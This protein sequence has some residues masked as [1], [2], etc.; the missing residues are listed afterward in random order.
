MGKSDADADA[1]AVAASATAGIEAGRGKYQG[2][3]PRNRSQQNALRTTTAPAFKESV[4]EMN[5][6]VLQC[7][8]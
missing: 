4:K 8:G 2:S 5:V 6:H 3:N 1:S 7:Y